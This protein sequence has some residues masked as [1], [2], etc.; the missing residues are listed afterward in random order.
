VGCSRTW[1]GGLCP[2]RRWP[3]T[4][5]VLCSR[6]R[7]LEPKGA[8][9]KTIR[10][11]RAQPRACTGE[12]P[13]GGA[14]LSRRMFLPRHRY[15]VLPCGSLLVSREER[16]ER[17]RKESKGAGGD[18]GSSM[19]TPPAAASC[20][21]AVTKR[22]ER[23]NEIGFGSRS[24]AVWFCHSEIHAQPLDRDLRP[25]ITG[26]PPSPGGSGNSRPR[27]RLWPGRRSAARVAR[28]RAVLAT[29][30]QK[31]ERCVQAE[32][33]L[34]RWAEQA[35]EPSRPAWAGGHK[36]GRWAGLLLCAAAAEQA[37]GR[38]QLSASCCARS[39]FGLK[40]GK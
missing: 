33:L 40:N 36:L 14:I 19:S 6:A 11:R 38:T 24:T 27:P 30:P 4:A 2:R 10:R 37:I 22:K 28:P 29:G 31:G 7:G 32:R 25:G 21:P 18:F 15:V 12:G 3:R 35:T 8:G 26:P 13:H 23:P 39:A 20:G 9:R 17:E 1:S 34:G 5:A 16:R